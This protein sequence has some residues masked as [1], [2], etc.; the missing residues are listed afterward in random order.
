MILPSKNYHITPD[1]SSDG[2]ILLSPE[3]TE[4]VYFIEF[5]WIDPQHKIVV[6]NQVS[7]W[8]SDKSVLSPNNTVT[9][10]W[11]NQQG[12]IFQ[13]KVTLDNYYMFKIEQIIIN[14]TDN[15]VSLIPYGRINRSR[16]TTEK[17][18]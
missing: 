10:T 2:I 12:L 7:I 11:D 13:I 8:T 17:S 15:V 6:P 14:N 4:G 3:N 5:G 1:N 9:L 18:Y 16:H